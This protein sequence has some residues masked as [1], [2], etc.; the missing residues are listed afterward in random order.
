MHISLVL[1]QIW[2]LH[3]PVHFWHKIFNSALAAASS[4]LGVVGGALAGHGV[5]TLVI[6]TS[7]FNLL[8]AASST[9]IL[10][11]RKLQA[12][13]LLSKQLRRGAEVL[14]SA[15]VGNI[16]SYKLQFADGYHHHYFY[17]STTPGEN[18]THFIGHASYLSCS[19]S[20]S[21]V[22]AFGLYFASQQ[23]NLMQLT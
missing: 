22:H 5:A 21:I 20:Y 17:W 15:F 14:R 3:F 8:A 19:K 4:P 13:F 16:H 11:Q 6:Y 7:T 18:T 2:S 1:L 10:Q 23:R 9:K 12:L